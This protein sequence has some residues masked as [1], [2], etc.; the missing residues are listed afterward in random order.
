M[1]S[2]SGASSACRRAHLG[3][4]TIVDKKAVIDLD[5]CT[6]C[7]ACPSS[8]KFKAIEITKEDVNVS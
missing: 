7:G 8:C 4:I 6:L 1:T 3:A 5:K 2:A